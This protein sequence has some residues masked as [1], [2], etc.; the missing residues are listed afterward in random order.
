MMI[1]GSRSC[2]DNL[3]FFRIQVRFL[4]QL[5]HGPYTHVRES[6]ALP[7]QYPAL[8]NTHTSHDPLIRRIDHS[9]NILIRQY[10]FRNV[11]THSCD[12]RIYLIHNFKNKRTTYPN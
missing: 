9:G 11:S 2:Q 6:Y 4:E 8:L 7:F 10:I 1:R 3:Y 5:L 12:N